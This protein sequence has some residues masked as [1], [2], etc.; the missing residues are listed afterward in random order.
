MKCPYC[1][2][3]AVLRDSNVVYG[4][5]KYYGKMWVCKNFPKCDAYVGCHEGTTIPLGR[6]ANQRLRNLK[7]EAHKQFDPLWKSGLMSRKEAYRWLADMLHIDCEDCHIGMFDIKMC[8]KVIHLCR[9]QNNPIINNY[10]A[11]HYKECTRPVF[12]R[13]Y[14]RG[15][16]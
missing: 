14:E 3:E 1:G 10:R 11:K 12:T 5:D 7:K 8:Q 16:K 4:N 2:A 15:K 9:K 6:L 13:G